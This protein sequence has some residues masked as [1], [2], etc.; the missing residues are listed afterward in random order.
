MRTREVYK[1]SHDENIA[2]IEDSDEIS[3]FID[4][5]DRLFYKAGPH[6]TVYKMY[7]YGGSIFEQESQIE[8]EKNNPARS[9]SIF[10]VY[11][12][13]VYLYDRQSMDSM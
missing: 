7:S 12:E 11:D 13:Y 10:K 6:I 9:L 5:F 8:L 1:V 2:K 3:A 4:R